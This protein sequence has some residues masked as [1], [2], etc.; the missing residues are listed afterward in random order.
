MDKQNTRTQS[1]QNKLKLARKGTQRGA[2]GPDCFPQFV[3]VVLALR[4]TARRLLISQAT[5]WMCQ[6][7]QT[8]EEWTTVTTE[9][10]IML[11]Q[12]SGSYGNPFCLNEK[13]RR[14]WDTY[15]KVVL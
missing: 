5:Y 11:L 1:A 7:S 8:W 3:Q 9:G 10:D 4:P 14:H 13:Q 2:L 12:T 6:E 15:C